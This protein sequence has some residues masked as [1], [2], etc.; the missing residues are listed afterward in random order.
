MM[1][2]REERFYEI[3]YKYIIIPFSRALLIYI[4]IKIPDS[5]FIIIAHAYTMNGIT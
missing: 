1:M 2:L 4:W 3:T 5:W